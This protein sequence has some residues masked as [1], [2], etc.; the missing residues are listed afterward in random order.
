MTLVDFGGTRVEH[1]VMIH[2][3]RTPTTAVSISL[4]VGILI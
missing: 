4:M 1:P 3:T 2:A